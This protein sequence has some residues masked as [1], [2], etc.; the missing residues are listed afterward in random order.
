MACM[1]YGEMG[2]RGNIF[3]THS[4]VAPNLRE[5]G[6]YVEALMDGG[7]SLTLLHNVIARSMRP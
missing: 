3:L 1:L 4:F 5:A 2:S 6:R 7:N